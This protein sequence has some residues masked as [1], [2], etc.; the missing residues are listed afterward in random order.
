MI[1]QPWYDLLFFEDLLART[2]AKFGVKCRL[3]NLPEHY[4]VGRN[5]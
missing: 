1:S 5:E 3:L 2:I 4:A